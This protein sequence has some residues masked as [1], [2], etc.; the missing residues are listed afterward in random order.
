MS[1]FA[2][3]VWKCEQFSSKLWKYKGIKINFTVSPL[4]LTSFPKCESVTCIGVVNRPMNV[5]V[6]NVAVVN[7]LLSS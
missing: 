1:L 3:L 7:S 4:E 6:F 5:S 2:L